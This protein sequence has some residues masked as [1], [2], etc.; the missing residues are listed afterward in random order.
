M[1]NDCLRMDRA[2]F[3]TFKPKNKLEVKKDKDSRPKLRGTIFKKNLN[4]PRSQTGKR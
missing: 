1:E 2:V 4:V 3:L